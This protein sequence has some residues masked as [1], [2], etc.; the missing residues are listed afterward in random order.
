MAP[1]DLNEMLGAILQNPEAKNALNGV[2]GAESAEGAAKETSLDIGSHRGRR[3]KER[4]HLLLAIRPY[5]GKNRCASVDRM[6][7]ALELYDIIEDT[8]LLKGGHKH[9]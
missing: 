2:L 9:V 1:P 4:K 7:R 8:Q 3:T 6:I 5:L